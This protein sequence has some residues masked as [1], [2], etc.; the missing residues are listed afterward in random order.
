MEYCS[1]A[2][3]VHVHTETVMILNL[4]YFLAGFVFIK[5]LLYDFRF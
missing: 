1:N 4:I 2:V 3:H 5:I